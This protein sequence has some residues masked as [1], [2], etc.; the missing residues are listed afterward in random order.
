[1]AL[2]LAQIPLVLAISAAYHVISTIPAKAMPQK[3]QIPTTT[4]PQ[5]FLTTLSWAFPLW[6]VIN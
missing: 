3:G 6:K 4:V 1:M 5:R 2:S